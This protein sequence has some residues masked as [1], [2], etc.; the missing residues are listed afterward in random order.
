MRG[1]HSK[2]RKGI[3]SSEKGLP[4]VFERHKSKLSTHDDS[5]LLPHRLSTLD[6]YYV[7]KDGSLQ[8]YK[9][10]QQFQEEVQF[11][12]PSVVPFP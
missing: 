3:L 9:V 4:K 5:D 10:L 7:P 1:F 8:S 6:T 11:V 12:M 2:F